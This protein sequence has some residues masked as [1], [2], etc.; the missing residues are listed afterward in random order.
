MV[1]YGEFGFELLKRGRRVEVTLCLALGPVR[2]AFRVT[3]D[4]ILTSFRY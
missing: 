4:N 1:I 2:R 3:F